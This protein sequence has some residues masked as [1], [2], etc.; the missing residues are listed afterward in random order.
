MSE[1][2]I[3]MIEWE[4]STQPV[5]SWQWLS[6]FEEPEVVKCRSVGWL[7]HDSEHVKVLAPNIG[8]HDDSEEIQVSGV[9]RIPAKA[10]LSIKDL[11]LDC[12]ETS[13]IE[14]AKAVLEARSGMSL[15]YPSASRAM[16]RLSD[17][18][19]GMTKND[20]QVPEMP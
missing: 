3:V 8:S 15:H 12:S 7:I 19:D 13:L 14:A 9:I 18:V 17:V 11:P 2:R 6:A 10:V 1:H 16:V 20:D 4:D 5:P